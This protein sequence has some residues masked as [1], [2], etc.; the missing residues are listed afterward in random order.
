M[1]RV[2]VDF[3]GTI[4]LQDVG[5]AMFERF[6]GREAVDAVAAYRAGTMSA[7]A[8][9]DVECRACGSPDVADLDAFLDS[10]GIDGSFVPFSAFAREHGMPLTILSDGMDYYIARILGRHGLASVPFRANHLELTQTGVP[11]R[12]RLVPSFPYTDETCDRCAC[13]KR[14]Q[15]ITMSADEDVIVYVGEGYSDRCPARYADLVFAKDELLQ[16]C[17]QNG[18]PCTEYRS[19]SDVQGVLAR[20]LAEQRK[21]SPFRKRRQAEL[22]RREVIMAE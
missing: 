7:A 13:C 2:F 17:R 6:G 22:A 12:I 9:F 5:D 20:R 8:C 10:C 4:T 16:H 14:N 19:F 21:R 11:G 15:M 1:I 3:D 18:I